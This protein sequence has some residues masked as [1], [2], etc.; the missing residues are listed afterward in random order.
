MNLFTIGFTQK[1]AQQFFHLLQ[2]NAIDCVVDIRLRPGGQLSGFAKQEDLRFFLK[3]LIHCD[4]LYLEELA[5]TKEILDAYRKDH[6]W[7]TYKHLFLQLLKDRDIL[8][9]LDKEF[10][11]RNQ[12]C[13]LC[14]ELKPNCCH[15]SLV[16]EYL[17]EN[18]KNVSIIHL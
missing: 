3:E 12:C 10:F 5:P 14:S 13:F 11:E 7:A 17:A 4:F 16:A 15:R 8:E 9:R 1:T 6:D 2:N 18:W